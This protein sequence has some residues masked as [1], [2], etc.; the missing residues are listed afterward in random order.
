MVS[1]RLKTSD[2]LQG[3]QPFRRRVEVQ[4]QRHVFRRVAQRVE[5][6]SDRLHLDKDIF[7]VFRCV[8][9]DLPI[10]ESY[11]SLA[12]EKLCV[13]RAVETA[14]RVVSLSTRPLRIRIAEIEALVVLQDQVVTV[15]AHR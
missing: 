3:A 13:R 11:G 1:A 12:H 6:A 2:G 14:R 15:P 7:L 8:R 4:R 9:L 5:G 10:Q